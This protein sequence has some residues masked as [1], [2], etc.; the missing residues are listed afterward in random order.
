MFIK[1]FSFLKT[2]NLFLKFL[3][4]LSVF[5]LPCFILP[6]TQNP[7]EINKIYFFVFLSSLS[8][9]FYLLKISFSREIEIKSNPIF[10]FVF[11][12]F[13]FSLLSTFL[14][15]DRYFSLFGSF[16][17]YS[18]GFFTFLFLVVFSFLIFQIF[19]NPSILV[20]LFLLGTIFSVAVFLLSG[21]LPE[22][23]F[24]K[25]PSFLDLFKIKFFN[26]SSFFPRIFGMFLSTITVFL[27]IYF[28]N[29]SKKEKI[30]ILCLLFFIFLAL[31]FLNYKLIWLNLI[32]SFLCFLIISI[33]FKV[34]IKEVNSFA[35]PI[36]LLLLSLFFL[37]FGGIEGGDRFEMTQKESFYIA[38]QTL[39]SSIKN[40]FL[41]TGPA[42][43]VIDFSKFKPERLNQEIFWSLKF[44]QAKN[45]FL[46]VLIEQG[47]LSFSC[48]LL[49]VLSPIFYFWRNKDKKEIYPYFFAYLSSVLSLFLYFFS[50]ISLFVFWFFLS[51]FFLSHHSLYSRK[52]INLELPE[53]KIFLFFILGLSFALFL[54]LGIF[55]INNY[56]AELNYQKYLATR[57][58]EKRL[59]LLEKTV[60]LNPY[61]PIYHLTLGQEY[62]NLLFSETKKS[63][64]QNRIIF[65]MSAALSEGRKTVDISPNMSFSWEGLGLIAKNLQPFLD[66]AREEAKRNFQKA[67]ELDPK[68]PFLYAELGK[69]A[70]AEQ[71]LDEAKKFLEQGKALNVFY[72]DLSLLEA[73]IM[74]KEGKIKEALALVSSLNNQF[75]LNIDILFELGRLY[76]NQNEIDTAVEKWKTLLQIFPEHIDALYSLATAYQKKGERDVAISYLEKI[77]SINPNLSKVKEE[78]ENLKKK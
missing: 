13:F 10:L 61:N 41:G 70:L 76:F 64:D 28:F 53:T 33:Y 19:D 2:E 42:S 34:F 59:S 77:L 65:L 26:L 36:L 6:F 67:L 50:F 75:P 60:N 15:A 40:F 58:L 16:G 55:G 52:K 45:Y 8:L 23:I 56:L 48:L 25:L 12:L 18:N 71:N 27:T 4:G 74:E 20:R 32:L 72:W 62:V 9:F 38:F 57:D 31:F 22:Q 14:S 29:A 3:L 69:I 63:A 51:L 44:D 7:I 35:L 49:V 17:N 37:L 47:F 39:K 46:N 54:F 66:G 78:L 5:L 68:N 73:R 30:L 11:L 24:Q 1:E 21:F 43:F